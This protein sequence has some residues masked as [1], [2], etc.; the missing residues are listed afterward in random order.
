MG[1][2]DGKVVVISGASSGIGR[3]SALLMAR[4]G[5]RLVLTARRHALLASLVEEVGRGGGEA[6]AL[7][8]DVADEGHAQAVVDLALQRFGRLDVGY[9]NAAVLGP[10]R[11][12]HEVSLAEW[13]DTLRINLGGAFLAARHQLPLLLAQGHGSLVFTS[14]WVG[15]TGGLP[16]MA[17]YSATKAGLIGL[18]KSLAT[19]VGPQGVRVNALL[20][21][22]TD[23]EMGRTVA[24]TPEARSWVAGLHALKR[25][26]LPEEIAQAGVW[27]ASDAASFVTGS[28]F[29]VDGGASVQ[30]A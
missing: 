14:S 22:G 3:A 19:E 9:Y 20:P 8:G 28:A 21:G 26:A 30:K 2:L 4:E 6:V 29:L 23:T 5:A 27:L 18:V 12:L 7:A 1:L 16:H 10:L 17:T 13:N 11:P 15:Y 25:Q 24:N